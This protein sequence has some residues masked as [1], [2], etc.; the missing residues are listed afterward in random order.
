VRTTYLTAGAIALAIIVWLLSGQIASGDPVRHQTLAESNAE[1]LARTQD[2]APTKVR[3]R[4]MNAAP[5]FQHVVLRGKT[6]S[7][8]VVEV[9]SETSGR[10]IDRPVERGAYVAQGDLLCRLSMDDRDAALAEA[11]ESLNQARIEYDGSLKLKQRG[12]QSDTAIAQTKA[13]LAA[14]E[15]KLARSAL[16]VSRTEIRAPFDGVVETIHQDVGDYVNVSAPCV[17]VVDPDP[18]L[19][20]GRVAEKDVHRLL[21]DQTA[22]GL[23]SNGTTVTGPVTF[24]GQQSDPATRTYAVE[25]QIP[26]PQR[27]IRSGITTEI[28]IPVAEIMAQKVSPAVFTLDDAGNIGVRI[29]NADH[30]VELHP[31]TIIREATDGVWVSGLPNVAT[32]ITVGQE[33]VVPG[34]MVDVDFEPADTLPAAAPAERAVAPEADGPDSGPS[35][36]N[37]TSR[38]SRTDALSRP[39]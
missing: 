11:R 8:R 12:F 6:E 9:R 39:T 3:A 24:I 33:L 28:R 13:R 14:A 29:V 16:D 23:L 7:K 37:L 25:I 38:T 10:V 36:A 35:A 32:V 18:M 15:A 27:A 19:L 21:L 1:A 20:I 2:E 31:V 26:N 30:R 22:T 5:Q 17:T 4:V 34:E